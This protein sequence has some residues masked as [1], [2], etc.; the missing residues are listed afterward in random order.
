MRRLLIA[1]GGRQRLI[2][3]KAGGTIAD[4]ANH[5]V[6]Q[7]A[8]TVCTPAERLTALAWAS[9]QGLY[10][11]LSIVGVPGFLLCL[12]IRL[13]KWAHEQRKHFG[14]GMQA[15]QM[16]HACWWA[17]Q[18]AGCSFTWAMARCFT[19]SSCTICRFWPYA[20]G[21]DQASWHWWRRLT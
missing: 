16:M 12:H 19:A 1:V 13:P 17:P 6:R 11:S 9:F 4:G 10:L 3:Y 21:A 18:A 20:S 8:A 2:I 7:Y 14:A 5:F 15:M